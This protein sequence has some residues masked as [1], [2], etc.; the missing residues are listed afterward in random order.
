MK[1]TSNFLLAQRVN[2]AADLAAIALAGLGAIALLFTAFLLGFAS[3]RRYVV[4]APLPFSDELVGFLLVCIAFLAIADGFM[5]GRQVRLLFLWKLLPPRVR[6]IAYLAGH[7]FT[8]AVLGAIVRESYEFARFSFEIGA[9]S[10]VA[11]IIEWPW[12]AVIPVSVSLL[13]I[14][15]FLRLIA[16]IATV[17]AGRD[18]QVVAASESL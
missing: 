1:Q 7:V 13:M 11:D 16:D 2:R 12:M 8:L 5:K 10:P 15:V 3:I 4:D 18:V 14:C 6:N 9:K 17:A